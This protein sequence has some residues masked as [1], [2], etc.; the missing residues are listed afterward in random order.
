MMLS[1]AH[2]VRFKNAQQEYKK[3]ESKVESGRASS[4]ETEH[5]EKAR[6]AFF[7]VC[8]QILQELLH[9]EDC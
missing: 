1:G 9:E 6:K 2:A 7:E 4:S 3:Y 8:E 5:Y